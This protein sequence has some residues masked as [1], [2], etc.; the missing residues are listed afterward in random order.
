MS[1][2]NGSEVG[3]ILVPSCNASETYVLPQYRSYLVN[4]RGTVYQSNYV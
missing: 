4:I 1:F 3:S 2:E